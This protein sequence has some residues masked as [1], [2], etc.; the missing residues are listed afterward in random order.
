MA[1]KTKPKLTWIWKEK[2][3]RL[4]MGWKIPTSRGFDEE[5]AQSK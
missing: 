4:E 1:N 3:P 5:T 2:Q